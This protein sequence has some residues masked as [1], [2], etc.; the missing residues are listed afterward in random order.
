MDLALELVTL[1]G[2][3]IEVVVEKRRVE[4]EVKCQVMRMEQ[5]Y[6]P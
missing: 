2:D 5:F 4:T 1:A 6:T 3:D